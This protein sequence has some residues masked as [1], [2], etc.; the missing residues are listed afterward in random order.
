LPGD[1]GFLRFAAD[2]SSLI[3]VTHDLKHAV[4]WHAQ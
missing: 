2:G 4:V 1:V 3:A